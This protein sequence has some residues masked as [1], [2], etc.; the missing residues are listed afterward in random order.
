[1]DSLCRVTRLRDKVLLFARLTPDWTHGAD[2][3][4]R[5]WHEDLPG[6]C[7]TLADLQTG[8]MRLCPSST[9]GR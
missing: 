5:Q 2:R 4:N 7:L 1:M 8:P 9:Q 6:I 3:L